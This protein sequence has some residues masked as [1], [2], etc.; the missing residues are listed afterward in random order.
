MGGYGNNGH[1][2]DVLMLEKGK[3]D[4]IKVMKTED[5]PFK[6]HNTWN[7]QV[8]IESPNVILAL[9]RADGKDTTLLRYNAKTFEVLAEGL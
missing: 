5:A 6:F 8:Q 3:D 9:V 2:S 1:L 7:N 4:K